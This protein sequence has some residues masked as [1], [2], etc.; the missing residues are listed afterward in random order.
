MTPGRKLAYDFLN[1]PQHTQ[2]SIARDL[3]LTRFE[4][5]G[6]EEAFVRVAWFR[7]ARIEGKMSAFRAAI[8]KAMS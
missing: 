1:L 5:E 7:R 3:G 6:H 4:D 8:T 2:N